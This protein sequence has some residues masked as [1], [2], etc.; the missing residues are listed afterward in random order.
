MSV[1]IQNSGNSDLA[2]NQT[3]TSSDFSAQSAD[4]GLQISGNTID[5]GRYLITAN[6]NYTTGAAYNFHSD[7]D[8]CVRVYDKQTDTYVQVFGD[9]HVETS[10]GTHGEFKRDGLVLDLQDGTQIQVQPTD[11]NNAGASHI[12][13][14]SVTKDNQTSFIT[15][16][17]NDAGTAHV[18]ISAPQAGNAFQLNNSFDSYSD[19]VLHVGSSLNDLHFADGSSMSGTGNTELDGKGGGIQEF[20]GQRVPMQSFDT[21]L[22]S[23]LHMASQGSQSV[24]APDYSAA[25]VANLRIESGY[26]K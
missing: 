4:T 23:V 25:S 26:G 22:Q 6:N 15:G 9:P 5:T 17:Y 10:N 18:Q 1:S 3:S 19:T 13:A 20:L 24:N 8:G 21:M 16:L 14:V 2:V 11:L 7:T 12:N